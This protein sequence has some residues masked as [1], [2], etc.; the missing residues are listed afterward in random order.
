MLIGAAALRLNWK[1]YLRIRP[2]AQLSSLRINGVHRR[3]WTP[4]CI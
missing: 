1:S 3:V 2:D 4:S